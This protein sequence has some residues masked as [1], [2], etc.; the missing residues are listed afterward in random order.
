MRLGTIYPAC[1]L[2]SDDDES[3][4]RVCTSALHLDHAHLGRCVRTC[5]RRLDPRWVHELHQYL[6]NS[7]AS[8]L[9]YHVA[10]TGDG[11]MP[12]H[13]ATMEGAFGHGLLVGTVVST[14]DRVQLGVSVL[15]SFALDVSQGIAPTAITPRHIGTR[16]RE[17]GLPV[18]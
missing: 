6:A 3:R 15:T 16:I 5:L 13:M 2:T 18:A 17:L 12:V 1:A 10:V 8:M 14:T 7:G 4:V 11:T 9:L